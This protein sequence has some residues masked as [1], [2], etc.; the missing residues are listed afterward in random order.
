MQPF[1]VPTELSG[2]V[3]TYP[4]AQDVLTA[5]QSRRP[6]VR[7][8]I[9]RLWLSEGIP[10][11][12]KANPS[13]YEAL[14]IWLARRF[15]I[16]AKQITVIGSGRQGYSLSP[17]ATLGR[18]FGAQSDLDMSAISSTFFERLKQA[19]LRWERDYS[20][21]LVQPR[22]TRERDL[23]NENKRF[24]PLGIA[25]GFIDPHKI[26]TW[27]RYPEAQA[28]LDGL[29]RAHEKLKTTAGAPTLRRISLRVYID[30]DCFVR[31]IAISLEAAARYHRSTSPA[32][33]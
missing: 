6:D 11:A 29:W 17:N 28:T 21:G 15:D 33:P 5:L 14:R 20:G 22:H 18:V 26:P 23:W 1:E 24:C 12:F 30:W 16:Q 9:A 8:S 13:L 19:Y 2:F 4:A 3:H 31:Q 7:Y 25:H 10:F 32:R 27:W